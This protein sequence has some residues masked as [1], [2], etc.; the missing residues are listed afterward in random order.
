MPL[1]MTIA[2]EFLAA[3]FKYSDQSV[4]VVCFYNPSKSFPYSIEQQ[5]FSGEN[6][7]KT[8]PFEDFN[9]NS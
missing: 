8:E 7:E 5:E 2:E 4:L 9:K 1:R 3:F 6:C